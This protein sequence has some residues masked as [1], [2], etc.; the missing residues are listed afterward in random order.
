M[1]KFA[2]LEEH[3]SLQVL[4]R[5]EAMETDSG[6]YGP[7][8]LTRCDPNVSVETKMGCWTDDDEGWNAAEK[9]MAEKDL[10]KFALEAIEMTKELSDPA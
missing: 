3:H 5:V 6:N 9:Y 1:T 7:H 10:S 2:R 4:C 8:V